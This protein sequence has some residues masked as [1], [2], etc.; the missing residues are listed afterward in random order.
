MTIWSILSFAAAVSLLLYARKGQN[1]VWGTATVA[2]P[3]G[4]VIAILVAI[5]GSSGFDWW[6][7]GK[8][9]VVGALTGLAFEWLPRLVGR[10]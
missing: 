6:I 10:K 1:A 5:F 9:V 7:I 2:I 4:L 3:I 8:A